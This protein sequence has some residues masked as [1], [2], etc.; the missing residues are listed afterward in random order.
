LRPIEDLLLN[1]LELVVTILL[2]SIF[3]MSSLSPE[4]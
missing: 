1:L 3:P 4:E 2:L